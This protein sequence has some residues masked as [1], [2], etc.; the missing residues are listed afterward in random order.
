MSKL[1]HKIIKEAIDEFDWVNTYNA[2]LRGQNLY[3]MM[4]EL[5]KLM[6]NRYQVVKVSNS[7]IEINDSS[8]TY[9]NY[10]EDDFTAERLREDFIETLNAEYNYYLTPRV[11]QEYLEL[12][13]VLEPIIGPINT[14]IKESEEFDWVDLNP[15]NLYGQRLFNTIDSLF[16][17]TN[18]RYQIEKIGDQDVE[19]NDDSG[20]YYEYKLDAFTI[21]ELI[22]DFKNTFNRPSGYLSPQVR[23][24]Y[25]QLAK[26]LEPIIGPINV[27]INES[28]EFD[29]VDT[30]TS[31]LSGQR[32]ADTMS[33][34]FKMNDSRSGL[35]NDIY[36]VETTSLG[37]IE[38]WDSGG[39]Y[40]EYNPED[41]TIDRVREDLAI[42]IDNYN[43]GPSVRMDYSN[44][45]RALAPIIGP[46]EY[47]H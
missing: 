25:L 42:N 15:S 29:W 16:K 47:Y 2:Q 20:I 22:S 28:E 34:L 41:F 9:Y 44:L 5:F 24:E 40:L 6:N 30:G 26:T 43:L 14:T 7:T 33:E 27:T 17:A 39:Y 35:R 4:L 8:G 46:M 10:N 38:I 18:S 12:A 31:N 13:K 36:W 1:I 23:Q 3:D 19:I 21:D 45:A 37:T 32:L 11:K